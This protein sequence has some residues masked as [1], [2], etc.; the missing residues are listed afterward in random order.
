MQVLRGARAARV[1]GA[2]RAPHGGAARPMPAPLPPRRVGVKAPDSIVVLDPGLVEQLPVPPA[3]A[4]GGM[5]VGP[6]EHSLAGRLAAV[7]ADVEG[8]RRRR[9]VAEKEIVSEYQI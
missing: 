2:D 1:E 5:G 9:P 8:G 3:E 4:V 6:E 7:G